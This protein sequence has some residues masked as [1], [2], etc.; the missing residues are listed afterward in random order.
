MMLSHNS[1]GVVLVVCGTAAF[2]VNVI[3]APFIYNNGSD[4]LTLVFFR[5]LTISIL[6]TA[7]LYILRN[8]IRLPARGLMFCG[9]IGVLMTAQT[10]AFFTAISELL[11]NVVFRR[12][13]QA[14]T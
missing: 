14:A 11:S 13:N 5:S 9:A 3:V 6:L 7:A 10:L 1:V 8:P 2:A 4:P 12:L